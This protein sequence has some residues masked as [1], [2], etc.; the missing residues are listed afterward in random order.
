MTVAKQIRYN[1]TKQMQYNEGLIEASMT[2]K[3]D[4]V[5]ELLPLADPSYADHEALGWA[6]RN[7]NVENVRGIVNATDLKYR[8]QVI[9]RVQRT[10]NLSVNV[11]K[12][13]IQY[14]NDTLPYDPLNREGFETGNARTVLTM[15][16]KAI[17]DNNIAGLQYLLTQCDPK[18]SNCSLLQMAAREG[19][20]EMI[21]LLYPLSDPE[22]TTEAM[23]EY[24]QI[25]RPNAQISLGIE[26]INERRKQEKLHQKLTG[27][28]EGV[29]EAA[30]RKM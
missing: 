30:S 19:H 16:H 28:V 7:N 11:M 14:L 27:I 26:R 24:I 29:G 3:N 5:K 25:T 12:V 6:L 10:K 18:S 1:V 20:D 9:F 4:M 17:E 13:F 15:A 8:S 22:K 21:D 2:N 23:H